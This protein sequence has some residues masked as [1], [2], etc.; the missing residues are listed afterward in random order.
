MAHCWK[1]KAFLDK[2]IF[3]MCDPENGAG[4]PSPRQILAARLDIKASGGAFGRLRQKLLGRPVA[5]LRTRL[6]HENFNFPETRYVLGRAPAPIDLMHCHNLHGG[7]FD[8]RRLRSLSRRLPVVVTLHDAWLLSGHCAHSFTCERWKCGCGR[9]C[10]PQHLSG[11]QTRC[12][13]L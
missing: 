12:H 5:A 13:G 10:R 4:W 11:Y 6:G 7:Y 2:R 9:S 8:L 1:P 3:R